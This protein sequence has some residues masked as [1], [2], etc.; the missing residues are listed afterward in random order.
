MFLE[1]W[2]LLLD[3]M[4]KTDQAKRYD[5]EVILMITEENPI[6]KSINKIIYFSANSVKKRLQKH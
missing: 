1:M 5:Q 3:V 2:M 6:N 4:D